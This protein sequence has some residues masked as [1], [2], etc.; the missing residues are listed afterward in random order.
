MTEEWRLLLDGAAT[1]A[2]NMAVDEALL[3]SVQ[4]PTLR[5][6]S[7]QPYALSLGYFQDAQTVDFAVCASEGIDVVRRPT[8]GRA[9]LHAQ[10]V[11]YS[12]A[13]PPQHPLTDVGV[14][15]SYRYLSRGLLRGLALLGLRAELAKKPVS[16][17]G[18]AH[19]HRSEAGVAAAC[20]DAPSWYELVVAGHKVVGSAQVRRKGALLQHGSVPLWLEPERLYGVLRFRSEQNRERAAKK[21]GTSAAGLAQ[22]IGRSVSFDEGVS[23]LISGFEEALR[24]KTS[25]S[26]LSPDEHKMTQALEVK[27]RSQAWIARRHEGSTR[28]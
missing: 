18:R 4:Q 11:T 14:A 26:S 24:V 28:P 20:F 12:I 3:D 23:A 6:Y 7:W 9:I 5:F 10:E 21:L 1:G 2:H 8:G 22:L 15:E 17:Q 25:V 19:A 13:L 16:S 27:H